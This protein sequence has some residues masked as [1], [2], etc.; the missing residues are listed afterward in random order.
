MLREIKSLGFEWSELSHGIRISLLPGI[1][2]AVDA[3]ETSKFPP[4]TISARC[5]WA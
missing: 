5:Q 4:C 2:E 3:G 1:M